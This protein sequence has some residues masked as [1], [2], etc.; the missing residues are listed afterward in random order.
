M[1]YF[2]LDAQQSEKRK[3][4]REKQWELSS[5]L[6]IVKYNMKSVKR[7]RNGK[8]KLWIKL[9]MNDWGCIKQIMY[10]QW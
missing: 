7:E 10:E 1:D 9:M 4:S 8:E 5:W 2:F 3:M 6:R